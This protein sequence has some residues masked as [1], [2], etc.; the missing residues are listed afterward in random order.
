MTARWAMSCWTATL[1]VTSIAAATPG[2][3]FDI[4]G[5]PPQHAVVM[6]PGAEPP[7]RIPDSPMLR[8][9]TG[10]FDELTPRDVAALRRA[11][12]PETRVPADAAVRERLAVLHLSTRTAS[13]R[14]E[15]DR[16][17]HG[18]ILARALDEPF[19]VRLEESLVRPFLDRWPAPRPAADKQEL[20]PGVE[21]ELA[22]PYTPSP[23]R[24]DERTVCD[25]FNRGGRSPF[26]DPLARDLCNERFVARRPAAHDPNRPAGLLVWISPTMDADLPDALFPAADK[27]DLVC[28]SPGRA[29][30]DRIAVDRFQLALDAVATASARWWID[31]DQVYVAGMSGGGRI[32]SMLWACFPDIFRGG[33]GVVGMNSSDL[34][35]IGDGRYWPKTHERPDGPLGRLLATQR[36]AAI[37]GPRDF[38]FKEIGGRTRVMLRQGLAVRVFDFADQQHDMTSADHFTQAIEWTHQPWLDAFESSTVDAQRLLDSYTTRYGEAAPPDDRAVKLLERVTIVG[39]WTGPAWHA[40][41]LLG[42]VAPASASDASP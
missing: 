40:A 24:L 4:N 41:A 8:Q 13:T 29:G 36:F 16:V 9:L 42:Y 31:P 17:E 20:E 22:K 30:N 12:A 23:F 37:T 35:G 33:V 28:I 26:A 18:W 19:A 39:P 5:R 11:I 10:V 6:A 38:N 25:R 27:F 15:I 7:A 34:V 3:I 1:L 32:A 14:V 21:G 2:R